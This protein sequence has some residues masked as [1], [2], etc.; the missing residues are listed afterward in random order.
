MSDAEDAIDTY[1]TISNEPDL[2][3]Q[4]ITVS[5]CDQVLRVLDTLGYDVPDEDELWDALA[6]MPADE[7]EEG[8]LFRIHIGGQKLF[9][10]AF[11]PTDRKIVCQG[12]TQLADR[13]HLCDIQIGD[14]VICRGNRGIG[15]VEGLSLLTR[16]GE[17]SAFE[18]ACPGG[19][20]D[21][22]PIDDCEVLA[23]WGFAPIDTLEEGTRILP[24]IIGRRLDPAV[25]PND[26]PASPIKIIRRLGS[27]PLYPD[28][29]IRISM[30]DGGIDD[31]LKTDEVWYAT[32]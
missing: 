22:F 9:E 15:R 5:L 14:F 23:D 2:H 18:V 17:A 29:A 28:N 26:V 13:V 30:A 3:T 27:G 20:S 6:G 8:D 12:S 21:L 24:R 11:S 7:L 10:V 16:N 4:E 25:H 32:Q 19:G 31:Y 1:D